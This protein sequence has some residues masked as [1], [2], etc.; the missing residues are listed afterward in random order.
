MHEHRRLMATELPSL[1]SWPAMGSCFGFFRP[2]HPCYDCNSCCTY[3]HFFPFVFRPQPPPHLSGWLHVP[4][5]RSPYVSAL[6]FFYPQISHTKMVVVGPLKIS[7]SFFPTLGDQRDLFLTFR[8]KFLRRVPFCPQLPLTKS[9]H[10][11]AVI[12]LSLWLALS[13][14]YA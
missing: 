4:R 12:L 9:Q 2:N 1:L 11:P 7:S 10:P 5:A 8:P 6:P 13:A 14:Q 3:A